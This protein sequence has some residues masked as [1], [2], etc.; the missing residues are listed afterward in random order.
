VSRPREK[1]TWRGPLIAVVLGALSAGCG[2]DSDPTAAFDPS[3]SGGQ[4]GTGGAG[5]DAGGSGAEG[6]G[7]AG[8]Q[9]RDAGGA[10]SSAEAGPEGLFNNPV[11]LLYADSE[12]RPSDFFST[13]SLDAT[14][15]AETA[16]A[17]FSEPS[18]CD[19]DGCQAFAACCTASGGCCKG[20]A[21][22]ALPTRLAFEPCAGLLVE[23]CA[24]AEG[25]TA[26]VLGVREP[27]ITARGLVPN[28]TPTE[29][30]G[31]LLGESVNLSSERVSL[32]VQFSL[33][34]GC[35]S[36]CLQ[37]AGVGFTAPTE[38][39]EFGGAEVALLLSGSRARVSLIVDDA[40]V[41]AFEVGDDLAV[42]S[43]ELSPGG[44]VEVKRDGTA[45]GVYGFKPQ[46]IGPVRLALFGRNATADAN[47][48]AVARIAAMTELCDSPTAW[49]ARSEVTVT[50]GGQPSPAL[51]R[52]RAPSVA[53]TPEG[54]V[55]AFELGGQLFVG[56]L[57]APGT[58]AVDAPEA[59]V[60]ATE[61]FEAGGLTDP[62]LV[63]LFNAL[64]VFYTAVDGSGIGS[65]GSAIVTDGEA[66]KAPAPVLAPE[67]DAVSLDSPTVVVQDGL[68]I[69]IVHVTRQSGATE[70]RAYYSADPQTGWMRIVDGALE[71]L[72]RI[73]DS[74]LDITDPSLIVHN[75]AYHLYY[76]RR[77][78]TRWAIE[79][80]TSD[81]LLFWRPVGETLGPSGDAF[82]SLGARGLDARSLTDRVEAVYMGQDGVSFR[83]GYAARSAPSDTAATNF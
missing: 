31:A 56:R 33:P 34:I 79:L 52:G 72:S 22:N 66:Q 12:R 25:V 63:W 73:E 58:I 71:S 75:S 64:Y 38:R 81:E 57:S 26:Q 39:G 62:E 13:D 60:V 23:S 59:N 70:L 45:L 67:G 44:T 61:A 14:T 78:G 49:E 16:A 51:S 36:T 43:L 37:S 69:L 53:D 4:A 40:V 83:L 76:A 27:V 1:Q 54:P 55:A 42:W 29:E 11:D 48:A 24:A 74:A 35:G 10:P 32:Q 68:I 46:V 3:G 80:A 19:V 20:T 7:G 41:D 77:S 50:V 8:G 6:V 82:D 28:G 17:C 18:A 15:Y 2:A 65:I 5:L 21:D 9:D 30:G 47:S